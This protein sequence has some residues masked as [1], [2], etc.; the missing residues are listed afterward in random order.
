MRYKDQMFNVVRRNNI[1]FF[2]TLRKEIHKCKLWTK[3]WFL[4]Y[5]ITIPSL[6]LSVHNFQLEIISP[7]KTNINLIIVITTQRHVLY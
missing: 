6:S 5:N 1:C 7:G 4:A 3:L 2:L